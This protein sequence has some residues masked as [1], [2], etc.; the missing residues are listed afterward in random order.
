MNEFET[1]ESQFLALK[2]IQGHGQK[3]VP[4][5]KKDTAPCTEFLQNYKLK[6]DN[7]KDN[8]EATEELLEFISAKLNNHN[9]TLKELTDIEVKGLVKT[10]TGKK[11]LGIHWKIWNC[12]EIFKGSS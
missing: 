5:R 7:E 1:I 4:D 10:I 6:T 3:F 12:V 8:D 11:S 9:F 2:P